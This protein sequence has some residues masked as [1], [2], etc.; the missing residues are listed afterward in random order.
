MTWFSGNMDI[1]YLVSI[2]N[3]NGKVRRGWGDSENFLLYYW[4]LEPFVMFC[5]F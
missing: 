4:R 3:K 1:L 2:Q 5:I